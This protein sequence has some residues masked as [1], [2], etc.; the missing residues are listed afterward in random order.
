MHSLALTIDASYGRM[1]F[2]SAIKLSAPRRNTRT[3]TDED[4]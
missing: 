1:Y 2:F 4:P 3:D